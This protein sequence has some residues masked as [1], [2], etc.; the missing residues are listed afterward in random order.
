MIKKIANLKGRIDC[1]KCFSL[2]EWDNAKDIKVSNGNKYIICPECGQSLILKKGKE[3][4]L[5]LFK[6]RITI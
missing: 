2:L 5:K 6:N 1:P 3:V 4:F